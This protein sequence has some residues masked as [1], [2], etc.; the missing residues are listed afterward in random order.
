MTVHTPP[1]AVSAAQPHA[2]HYAGGPTAVL[3]IHGLTG[4]PAELKLVAKGLARAGYSVYGVQL[5][6]H[7]GSEADLTATGWKDWLAS[8]LDAFDRIRQH[9][10]SVF[11]GGLSMGA[12]LALMVASHRAERAAGC[13]LYSPT[14]FYDGWSVPRGS[15]LLH[16]AILLG[17]GRFFRFRE[18]YPYGIKDDRLRAR[19]Q[20]AMESGRSEEAGLLHMPGRSLA[21][22]L[23][24]IRDL[25]PRL[26]GLRLPALIL[27]AREDDVTSIRN[28]S[29]LAARLGGNV[30]KILLENSYHMI[31]LDQEREL[32][33]DHSVGF[34]RRTEPR[35]LA[36]PGLT[37]AFNRGRS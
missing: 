1:R 22:L 6:G 29:Y 3:L 2:F 34:L 21:Q 36:P 9:H 35:R 20:A 8:A 15:V 12:L 18:N 32:V 24:L 26:P 28:A 5:A 30:E 14:M 19:V 23:Y 10:D 31:T 11:V 33:I 16:G 4:T 37:L 7:C 25:K 17:L 13:L 27:H